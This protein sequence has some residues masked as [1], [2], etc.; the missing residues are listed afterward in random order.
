LEMIQRRK[1]LEPEVRI[2]AAR[3][4]CDSISTVSRWRY[5]AGNTQLIEVQRRPKEV[6][7][8]AQMKMASSC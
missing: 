3:K 2:A 6:Y 5:G 1:L 8:E 7:G 4:K